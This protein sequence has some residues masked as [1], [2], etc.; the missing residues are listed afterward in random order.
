MH[1]VVCL[2]TLMF[3]VFSLFFRQ[4]VL[5]VK[6][7]HGSFAR[8]FVC[9]ASFTRL[10]RFVRMFFFIIIYSEQSS[11]PFICELSDNDDYDNIDNIMRHVYV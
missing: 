11:F 10:P 5:S 4:C 3:V 7:A 8:S 6:T 1:V 9:F 2:L